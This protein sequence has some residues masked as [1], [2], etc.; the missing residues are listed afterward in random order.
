MFGSSVVL[1]VAA[2]GVI[3]NLTAPAVEPVVVASV[4]SVPLLVMV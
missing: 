2:V 4:M 3:D 1:L